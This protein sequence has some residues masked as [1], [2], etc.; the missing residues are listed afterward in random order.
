MGHSTTF[1]VC[2]VGPFY[3]LLVCWQFVG[4]ATLTDRHLCPTLERFCK[5][6]GLPTGLAG[7]TFLAMAGPAAAQSQI[8]RSRTALKLELV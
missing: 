4:L 3:L 8:R 6:L 2:L 5:S 1:L 7:A